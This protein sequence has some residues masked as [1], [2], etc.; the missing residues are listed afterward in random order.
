MFFNN[1]TKRWELAYPITENDKDGTYYLDNLVAYDSYDNISY[2]YDYDND[3]NYKNLV[4]IQGAQGDSTG[5]SISDFKIEENGQ[6]LTTGDTIHISAKVIDPSGVKDVEVV[7]TTDN[8]IYISQH[9]FFNN[10]TKRWELAYP[11]TENDKDGTYHLDNLVAY[12]FYDNI[13]YYYDYDIYPDYKNYITIYTGQN[14]EGPIISNFEIKENG[15]T[16]TVGDTIH[17]SAK[18]TD[19]SG[20]KNVKLVLED[21]NKNWKIS[22]SMIYDKKTKK[23]ILSYPITENDKAGTFHLA[24]LTAFDSYDNSSTYYDYDTYPDYKNY[25]IVQTRN[26]IKPKNFTVS[27]INLDQHGNRIIPA[28]FTNDPISMKVVV[29]TPDG[30]FDAD[31]LIRSSELRQTKNTVQLSFPGDIPNLEPGKYEVEIRDLTEYVYD[32]RFKDQKIYL[33]AKAWINKEKKIEITLIWSDEK[34]PF[35]DSPAVYPLPEDEIGS[36]VLRQDGKKE[37]LV[38]HTFDICMNYLGDEELCSGNE[39]CYHK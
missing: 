33:S 11:I 21:D 27:I 26:A 34:D 22:S 19:P 1:K 38:F 24:Y 32:R 25:V 28:S 6:T 30:E 9:L 4:T 39:R 20:V 15:E 3:H 16:L 18:I 8:N 5:P 36:Y 37:Y 2:Y 10:K 12:D 17:I 31:L 35:D 13:S 29:K 14:P 23:W 7:L